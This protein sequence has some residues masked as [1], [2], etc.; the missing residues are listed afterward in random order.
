[1]NRINVY[2]YPAEDDYDALQD[3]PILDGWFD[4]DK[5]EMI[6]QDTEWDGN[7]HISVH[8]RSQWDSQ[9][10]YRTAGG[11][12]VLNHSSRRAAWPIPRYEFITDAQAR[13]WLLINHSDNEIE[14]YFGKVEE[15]VGPAPTGRPAIGPAINVRLEAGLL[16]AV[17]ARAEHEG[18]SRAETIRRLLLAGLAG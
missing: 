5:A 6:Q 14:K 16:A 18:Q 9:T 15:E 10:L 12:W 7:N 3:G 4:L 1:M 8:T 2:R 13:E 17:D 11:R